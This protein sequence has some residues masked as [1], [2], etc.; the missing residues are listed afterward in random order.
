[1]RAFKSIMQ[2][3]KNSEFMDKVRFVVCEP[4][5]KG[6]SRAEPKNAL[7]RLILSCFKVKVS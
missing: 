6:T 5:K 3:N 2:S 7:F 1:M 4:K